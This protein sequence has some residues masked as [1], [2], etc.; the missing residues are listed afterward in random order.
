[1]GEEIKIKEKE[2]PLPWLDERSGLFESVLIVVRARAL[3]ALAC[4]RERGYGV[5]QGR[6]AA[7]YD[8]CDFDGSRFRLSAALASPATTC[9]AARGTASAF[10]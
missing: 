2:R 5:G 7:T 10:G 9:A 6:C 1:M 4:S 8:L 3:A